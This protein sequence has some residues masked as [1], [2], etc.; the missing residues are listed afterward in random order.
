MTYYW[1]AQI[2]RVS[3]L[4]TCQESDKLILHGIRWKRYELYLT[5]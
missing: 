5:N 1:K 2:N 3:K 4:I